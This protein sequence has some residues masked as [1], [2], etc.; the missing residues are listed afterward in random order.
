MHKTS[1]LLTALLSLF[2]MSS[3]TS[4]SDDESKHDL[5]I[6]KWEEIECTDGNPSTIWTFNADGSFIWDN[7]YWSEEE[8]GTW[9]LQDDVI[10]LF[11]DDEYYKIKQLDKNYLIVQDIE[12]EDGETS[13]FIRVSNESNQD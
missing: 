6:G 1:R 4:C 13:T 3:F 8:Y 10:V 5:L 12:Y 9:K 7:T 2:L 11:D